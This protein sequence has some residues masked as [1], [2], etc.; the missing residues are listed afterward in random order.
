[1]SPAVPGGAVDIVPLG[2]LGQFGMNC[3]LL[4]SGADCAVIDAG[5]MFPPADLWGI[6][7]IARFR[8]SS[9]MVAMSD[10]RRMFV[11]WA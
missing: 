10:Q 9:S 1:M 4:R 7:I 8:S 11:S 2:G 5:M 3:T 6:D